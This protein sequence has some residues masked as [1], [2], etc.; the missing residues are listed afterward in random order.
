MPILQM[1][2][3]EVEEANDLPTVRETVSGKVRILKPM[4]FAAHY[5]ATS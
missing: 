4:I 3:F 5:A 2:K 1:R